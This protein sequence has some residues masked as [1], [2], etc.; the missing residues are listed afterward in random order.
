MD[1]YLDEQVLAL[2]EKLTQRLVALASFPTV[3]GKEY[4]AQQYCTQLN[5]NSTAEKMESP[6]CFSPQ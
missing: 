2:G 3:S 5:W 6:L 1:R 4:D